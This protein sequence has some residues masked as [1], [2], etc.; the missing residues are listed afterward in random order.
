MKTKINTSTLPGLALLFILGEEATKILTTHALDK[1]EDEKHIFDIDLK[2]D[3]K[4]YDFLV[5]VEQYQKNLER[6]IDLEVNSRLESKFN[7]LTDKLSFISS[8][9]DAAKAK[10]KSELNLTE[11]DY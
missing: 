1:K 9:F 6:M 7:E 8:M 10:I 4:E 5:L 3:G 2:I 11:D